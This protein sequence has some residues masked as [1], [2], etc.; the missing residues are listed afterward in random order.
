MDKVKRLQD[1]A[2]VLRSVLKKYAYVDSDAE[3]VLG[4]MTPL[5]EQISAGAVVPPR[6]HEYRWHFAST[7]S[8]LFKYDDLCEAAAEF[9]HALE[10]W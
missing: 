1:K 6:T 3:M 5:F 4:F 2:D 10:D 8:P 9:G 7:E